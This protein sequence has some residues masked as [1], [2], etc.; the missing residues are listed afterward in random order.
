MRYYLSRSVYYGYMQDS[1][2]S[3]V[4]AAPMTSR[5]REVY[6]LCYERLQASLAKVRAGATTRDIANAWP[7]YYDDKYKTCSMVQFAHAVGLHAS[8]GLWISRGF[9]LDYPEVLEENMYLAVET[10]AGDP[11]SDFSVRLEDNFIVTPAGYIVTSLF[12]FEEEA[13]GDLI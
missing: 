6:R 13:V 9:A 7:P 5:Q 10:W 4:V 12:P 8:E 2:R 3:W 11:G 1:A